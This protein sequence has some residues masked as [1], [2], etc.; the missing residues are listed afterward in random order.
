MPA[1]LALLT[2]LQDAQSSGARPGCGPRCVPSWPIPAT[3]LLLP[4]CLHVLSVPA[5]QK[6]TSVSHLHPLLRV[7]DHEV[8]VKEGVTVFAQRLHHGGTYGQVG[9]KVTVLQQRA[10]QAVDPRIVCTQLDTVQP[11]ASPAA[12]AA[13]SLCQLQLGSTTLHGC[14]PRPRRQ[15]P[16]LPPSLPTHHNIYV[17]PV[18]PLLHDLLAF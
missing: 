16:R 15:Q 14:P 5:R 13:V 17:Q 12:P 18:G 2:Q 8:A 11:P 4:A 6:A 1:A 7:A 9:D 10:T 3:G